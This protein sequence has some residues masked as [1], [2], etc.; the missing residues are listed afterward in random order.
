MKQRRIE[1]VE[2]RRPLVELN[3][4]AES[5]PRLAVPRAGCLGFLT[6]GLLLLAVLAAIGAGLR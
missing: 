1:R 3:L 4:I 6:R 5:K 2:R